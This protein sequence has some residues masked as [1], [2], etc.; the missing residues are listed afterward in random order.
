M[1]ATPAA[2]E[3]PYRTLVLVLL[4]LCLCF[5]SLICLDTGA[6][7]AA[8]SLVELRNVVRSALAALVGSLS[9]IARVVFREFREGRFHRV[10]IDRN[11]SSALCAFPGDH[12]SNEDW[13]G[14]DLCP[15]AWRRTQDS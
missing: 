2:H 3:T 14:S 7:L 13:V 5:L 4:G 11:R 9:Q 12:W 6:A 8:V 15:C 1:L 10:S